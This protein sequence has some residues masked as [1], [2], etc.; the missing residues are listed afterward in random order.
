MR[1][2]MNIF[3]SLMLVILVSCANAEKDKNVTNEEQKEEKT[4]D[5]DK[6]LMNV[7]ITLPASMFEGQDIDTVIADAKK[8][9]V[10]EVTKNEDGSLTYK[11][12]KA[13]H[14]EMMKE[15]ETS[16][17]DSVEEM[18][19]SGDYPSIKEIT[20]NKSFTEFTV[21]VDKNAYEN[22]MDGFATLGLGISGMMYQQYKG[23][24]PNNNKVKIVVKDQAT[25]EV[26]GDAVY[27]DDFDDE[28][29]DTS[30]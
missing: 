25:Q 3:L 6:G 17:V 23:V 24:D 2:V 13:K 16:I 12:S 10:K 1:N 30:S 21:E 27:P 22:S 28:E 20:Y 19:T 18:K 14:N 11:M 4:V 5:V 7:E 26:I 15:L 9:G 8:G 29:K